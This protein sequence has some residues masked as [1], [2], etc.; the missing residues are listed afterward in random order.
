MIS[1]VTNTHS[2]NVIR[3]SYYVFPCLTSAPSD[4]TNRT[5]LFCIVLLLFALMRIL[6]YLGFVEKRNKVLQPLLRIVGIEKHA[7]MLT[8]IRI[9]IVR[10]ENI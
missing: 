8:V 3:R 6:T 2:S 10:V 1:K 9:S 4:Y 7:A 5:S